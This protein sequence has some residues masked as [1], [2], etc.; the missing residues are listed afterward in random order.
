MRRMTKSDQEGQ[1][2]ETSLYIGNFRSRSQTPLAPIRGMRTVNQS[3][4]NFL[5]RRGCCRASALLA[6]RYTN[7][8]WQTSPEP[9]QPPRPG[10]PVSAQ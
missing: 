10:H 6:S 4:A 7:R 3:G 1:A 9:R 5:R 2:E 8:H